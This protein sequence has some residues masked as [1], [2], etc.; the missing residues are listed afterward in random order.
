M[1]R[2]TISSDNNI[3]AFPTPEAAQDTLALGAMSFTSQ[4]DL[5]KVTTD[6]PTSRLVE[7]WNAFAGTPGF[8]ELRPVKKFTDRKSAVARI[9]QAIQRLAPAP[10]SA[11]A[12][13]QAADV[14]P[15]APKPTKDTTRVKKAPKAPRAA[16]KA[17][18]KPTRAGSK[19]ARAIEMLKRKNGASNQEMQEAFGWAP[20]TIRGFVA[21]GLKVKMGLDVESFKTEAGEHRYRIIG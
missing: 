19:K 21:G 13:P 9:W 8:H 1:T 16:K 2:F 6:W 11:N 18:S 20:H 12:A 5:A 7:V 10:E 14:A 15:A 3:T 4:K 17:D